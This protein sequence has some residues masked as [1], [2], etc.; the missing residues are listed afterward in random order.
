METSQKKPQLIEIMGFPSISLVTGGR[1]SG[2]TAFGMETLREAPEKGLKPHLIGLPE[3]KWG[4]LPDYITPVRNLDNVPD[5]SA[6]FL[7]ESYLYAFARDHPRILNKYLYKILGVSRHKNWL[8]VFAT[9]TTRKL[10]VGVIIEADNIVMREPSWLHVRYE[11]VEIR[12]LMKATQNFFSRK[13]EP[14]KHAVIFRKGGPVAIEPG[15]P[16]FWSEE[17]S[18]GFSGVSVSEIGEVE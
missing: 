4:L 18:R 11:R 5:D 13:R 9:H 15:L 16:D 17:L 6:V 7:D 10:D 12:K 2:K 14:V 8:L 3:S 1:G